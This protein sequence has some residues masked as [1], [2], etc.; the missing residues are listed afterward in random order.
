[1]E[2]EL[3][4][5][6]K[7]AFTGAFRTKI[8]KF[9][10]AQGGSIFLDEISEMSS[11]LQV[12]LLR[13]LQ[14]REFERVGGV[15]SISADVRVIAA[16]NKDLDEEVK[17]GR[18][19]EDL[20]Y[21]LNVIPIALPPLRERKEDIPLLIKHFLA[22]SESN[23][24]GKIKGFSKEAMEALARHRWPGNVREME[25][26]V[27]RVVALCE[28]PI[29]DVHDLPEKILGV[30]FD[31]GS[32]AQIEL[33]ETGIDLPTAVDEFEKNLIVQALNRSNWVKNRAA[34]LLHLNRTTLV[35]KIKKQ[36]IRPPE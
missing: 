4:G 3:F 8:G 31:V 35:E 25:N 7:G 2:S 17:K 1:M 26:L 6:E 30:S 15:H 14:E 23:R 20:F 11:G 29:A 22:K 16:T 21:R 18:F 33:P 13:V 9:E 32:I 34:Q 36:G 12:K 19:R 5:H 10:L 27:E 24:Q 28:N